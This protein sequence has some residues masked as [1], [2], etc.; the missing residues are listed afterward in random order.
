ML[1]V[2]IHLK[3]YNQRTYLLLLIIVG[4]KLNYT[5][6]TTSNVPPVQHLT[7]NFSPSTSNFL[8]PIQV[9]FCQFE[10][11]LLNFSPLNSLSIRLLT[12]SASCQ[13]NYLDL[14]CPPNSSTSVCH[15]FKCLLT[16]RSTYLS[17]EYRLIKYLCLPISRKENTNQYICSFQGVNR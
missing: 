1:G 3:N 15:R 11:L 13:L 7:F 10:F 5:F 17:P 14:P 2:G 16:S 8:L 9:T 12:I 6:S 4:Q